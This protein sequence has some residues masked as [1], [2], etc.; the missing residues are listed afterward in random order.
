LGR[1]GATGAEERLLAI[2]TSAEEPEDLR[3]D[4]AEGLAEIGSPAAIAVLRGLADEPGDLGPLSK[5]LLA[6]IAMNQAEAT[7]GATGSST[8]DSTATSNPTSTST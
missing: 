6:E 7:A 8:E 3:M 4:A 2:A 5:E 1:L